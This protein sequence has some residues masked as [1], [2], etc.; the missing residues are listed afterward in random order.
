M[1]DYE[2]E[3]IQ[4]AVAECYDEYIESCSEESVSEIS[5]AVDSKLKEIGGYI[6]EL[7]NALG[8]YEEAAR[9][10]GFYAGYKAAL[11]MMQRA[12]K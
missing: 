10:A 5:A 6:E 8:E 9:R 7:C 2:F 1:T 4:E 3:S 12:G 11:L